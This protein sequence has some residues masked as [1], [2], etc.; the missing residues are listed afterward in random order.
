LKKEEKSKKISALPQIKKR[1]Q[2]S[3]KILVKDT[4]VVL[5]VGKI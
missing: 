5:Q 4:Y 1:H 3:F 2:I